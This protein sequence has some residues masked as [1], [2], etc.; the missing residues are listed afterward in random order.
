MCYGREERRQDESHVP[1]TMREEERVSVR[2]TDRAL[3]ER[4]S[5]GTRWGSSTPTPLVAIGLGLCLPCG[6][7]VA[8]CCGP[9][10]AR[11]AC[12]G[13]ECMTNFDLRPVH[14]RA[15]RGVGHAWSPGARE[16]GGSLE[17]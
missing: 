3:P 9:I 15:A 5:G 4:R 1:G 16:R 7:G 14:A 11:G 10:H 2:A 13:H 12:V 6:G 8:H 17:Q